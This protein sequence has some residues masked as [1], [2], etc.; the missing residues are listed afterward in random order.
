[1]QEERRHGGARG[2]AGTQELSHSGAWDPV[3]GTRCGVQ[4]LQL[5]GEAQGVGPHEGTLIDLG[6]FNFADKKKVINNSPRTRRP[7]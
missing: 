5:C 2:A 6:E 7:R 1:M 3:E 4:L